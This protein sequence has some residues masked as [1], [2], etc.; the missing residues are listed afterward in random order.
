MSSENITSPNFTSNDDFTEE[1][2]IQQYPNEWT[3]SNNLVECDNGSTMESQIIN[4]RLF[5][6]RLS[7]KL[8][9]YSDYADI[10]FEDAN[11]E[12][13]NQWNNEINDFERLWSKL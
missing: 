12:K 7:L 10:A 5:G 1:R 3:F 11:R 13:R 4:A 9:N 8:Q 2:T 6:E